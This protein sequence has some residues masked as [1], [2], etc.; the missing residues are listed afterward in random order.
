MA[1]TV[2]TIGVAGGGADT[3][4]S[5][6]GIAVM[7]LVTPSTSTNCTPDS[8]AIRPYE[9][10]DLMIPR[11]FTGEEGAYPGRM[12]SSRRL[13]LR[14]VATELGVSA[15][16]ISNAYSRPDQLSAA[17]RERILTTA[18]RLGYPGP[19]PV[20]A[21]LASGRVGAI[22]VA[23]ANRLSYA[24]DDPVARELLAGMT[25]VA[26]SAA[27]GLLLLPGPTDAGE[28]TTAISRA[29]VDGLLACSLADDDPVLVAAHARR[30]P[31]VVV[32]Q[33]RP[34]QLALGVPWIG[35]D[36]RTAAAQAAGHLLDLGHRDLGVVCFG[37]RRGAVRGLVD[38]AGQQAASY[39]VSRDR[40]AGYRDAVERRGL[41]WTRVP[42]HQGT[43]STPDEGDAGAIAVLRQ[44]PRPTGLLC[45]SD[46]LAEGA[47]RAARRLNLRIPEDLSV[48]GF[49]DAHPTGTAL[50]LTT[51]HQPV[52][53]KGEQAAT[54]LLALLRGATPAP[55]TTLPTTLVVRGSTTVPA[56]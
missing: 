42:V 53:A 8:T 32:D 20:A 16:T 30:L 51:V 45:L 41:D 12:P 26:E 15:K 21:G 39:A 7:A 50:A 49:D 40:L 28:R 23:Y 55:T 5:I 48:V 19:D 4:A 22:G 25:A 17:L 10:A 44:S 35:T 37:L 2:A 36:D 9:V 46:R 29:V 18:A 54:A 56:S 27:A 52:R 47:V 14:D 31:L 38:L 1:Y 3:P 24:F 43:D 13:T 6:A 33:P 34:A 11:Y